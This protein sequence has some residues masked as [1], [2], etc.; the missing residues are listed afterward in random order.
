[1]PDRPPPAAGRWR[2]WVA[3]AAGLVAVLALTLVVLP[4]L[5]S[6][7]IVVDVAP[8]TATRLAA[9]EEVDLLPRT[10][11]VSVG[12]RLEITNRDD[13]VHEVG[14]YTVAAGQTLRQTF[15]SVGVLEGAC[16]L[17]PSGAITIVVR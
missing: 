15:T 6:E 16:T 2:A 3:A 4:G 8:G 14:P 7:T 10:L 17:H 5:D 9:G 12:D 13:V 11:E 1:M